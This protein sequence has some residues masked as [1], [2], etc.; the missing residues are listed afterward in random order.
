M[1]RINTRQV[2]ARIRTGRLPEYS[3]G[4]YVVCPDHGALGGMTESLRFWAK[5]DRA[6]CRK[7]DKWIAPHVVHEALGITIVV[8]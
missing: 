2:G 7:C 5:H 6:F 1:E 3:E 8:D 4:G